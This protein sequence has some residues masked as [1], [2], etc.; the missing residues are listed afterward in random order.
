MEEHV[1]LLRTS[2]LLRMVVLANDGV[3]GEVQ[4][5]L[6]DDRDWTI[7]RLAVHLGGWPP[8]W[9]V[10]ISPDA[11]GRVNW[12]ESTLWVSLTTAQLRG[13]RGSNE[14]GTE[15]ADSHLQ[16]CARMIGC[17]V[18]ATDGQVGQVMDGLVEKA[19]WSLRC[20]VVN[21]APWLPGEKVLVSPQWG[22]GTQWR[23]GRFVLDR[24]R[25][26]V[27]GGPECDLASGIDQ[28]IA[29]ASR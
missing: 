19:T 22:E 14:D 23:K 1:V 20:L 7:G 17:E 24:S 10:L 27:R 12:A 28:F 4:D 18:F 5:V 9:N 11:V 2:D 8:G 13:S 3:M 21:C 16:S 15:S 29:I 6:V 25:E 26:K